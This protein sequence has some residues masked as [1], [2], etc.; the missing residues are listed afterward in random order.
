MDKFIFALV[1]FLA[2]CVP[3]TTGYK[4]ELDDKWKPLEYLMDRK[5]E[6][7]GFGWVETIEEN[8]YIYD[9]ET[10][11]KFNPIGTLGFDALMLHEREHS[12]RMGTGLFSWIWQLQYNSSKDFKWQEEEAG[13]EVELR[14]LLENGRTINVEAIVDSLMTYDMVDEDEARE[15]VQNIVDDYK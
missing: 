4:V 6:G 14:H 9:L 7:K 12:R 13:W 3:A 15:W 1:F 10:W 8:V 5:D 2:A 11:L